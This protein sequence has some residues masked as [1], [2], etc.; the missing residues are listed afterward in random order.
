MTQPLLLEQL[1]EYGVDIPERQLNRLLMEGHEGFD[2][3]KAELLSMGL[4]VSPGLLGL[5]VANPKAGLIF[6]LPN[7]STY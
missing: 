1:H 6:Y 7:F 3:E 4:A 5:K 2:E